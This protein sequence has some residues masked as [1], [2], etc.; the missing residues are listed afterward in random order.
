MPVPGILVRIARIV[1]I[2]RISR[3]TKI[4]LPPRL[5][6]RESRREIH[7]IASPEEKTHFDA[8]NWETL[9]FVSSI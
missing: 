9:D 8:E 2:D 6:P 5:H 7:H 3:I 1:R 4:P